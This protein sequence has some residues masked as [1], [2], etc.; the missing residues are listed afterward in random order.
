MS[1]LLHRNLEAKLAALDGPEWD[2]SDEEVVETKDAHKTPKK[3]DKGSKTTGGADKEE[4]KS[5]N[6]KSSEDGSS[7]SASRVVYLGHIPPAFE[8]TQ[9]L[10]FF[11][12]F[13]KITNIKLSRSRRTGTPRGYAFVEYQEEDVASIVAE[14]MSGYFLMGERR[15]VCHIVPKEK[16]HPKLFQG[17]KRNLA[18]CNSGMTSSS[19]IEYW[20]DKNRKVVN[21]ERSIQGIKKITK[22]LLGR[23]KKK[24]QQLEKLGIDYDFP[25]YAASAE[26]VGEDK[27]E[28]IQEKSK[29]RKVSEDESAL[30]ESNGGQTENISSDATSQTRKISMDDKIDDKKPNT[31]TK[32]TSSDKTDSVLK[33][34]KKK[35]SKKRRKSA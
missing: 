13:G 15:L 23:E 11:S 12:Q 1:K 22:R 30:I 24:R 25:G 33:K 28:K 14:A 8:E 9:I 17:A 5:K 18:F 32:N 29:K 31:P 4:N 2:S 20:Q 10:S 16:I 34:T 3:R 35:S 6:N 27:S 7:S 26:R 19:R 21:Q